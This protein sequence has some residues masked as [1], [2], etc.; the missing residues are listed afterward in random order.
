MTNSHIPTTDPYDHLQVEDKVKHPN[1]GEGQ[2]LQR[3]GVGDDTKFL[4]AFTEEG[5]RKL[6]AKYAK[7]KKIRP[8]SK[9]EEEK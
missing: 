4:V 9:K 8:T 6:L 3:S 2:I 1:F 5:E 7:L